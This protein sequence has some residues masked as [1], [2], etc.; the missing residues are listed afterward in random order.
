MNTQYNPHSVTSLPI[1]ELRR[2]IAPYWGDVDTTGTGQI[3]YRQTTNSTLLARAANEIQTA[4]SVSQN[5][6]SLFIATWNA[7]GYYPRMTNMVRL[8]NV[9]RH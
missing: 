5:V 7:V 8:N 3:Y 1:G 9:Y 2:F 6:S 4:F